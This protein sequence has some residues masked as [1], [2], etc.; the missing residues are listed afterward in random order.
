MNVQMNL[1]IF[2]LV[3]PH[4]NWMRAFIIW[5]LVILWVFQQTVLPIQ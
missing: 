1:Y 3:V 2:Y 4:L 5:R